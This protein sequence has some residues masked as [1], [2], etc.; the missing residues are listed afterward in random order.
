MNAHWSSKKSN[1][2]RKN[3]KLLT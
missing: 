2:F 1:F 3:I